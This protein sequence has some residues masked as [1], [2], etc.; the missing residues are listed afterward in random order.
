M[1]QQLGVE[2]IPQTA[3]LF[4]AEKSEAIHHLNDIFIK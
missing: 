1:I 3:L 2:K 4:G